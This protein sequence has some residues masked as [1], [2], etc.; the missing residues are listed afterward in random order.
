[1]LV[2]IGQKGITNN[3]YFKE[4]VH[5]IF[6]STF[7]PG[8]HENFLCVFPE[9]AGKKKFC[10]LFYSGMESD[11]QLELINDQMEA[12]TILFWPQFL[13]KM[14]L[15]VVVAT[16]T[17]ILSVFRLLVAVDGDDVCGQLLPD[18]AVLCCPL[19]HHLLLPRRPAA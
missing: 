7:Q 6:D 2:V 16:V 19:L 10:L 15:V 3:L 8:L 18:L 1:M 17:Y 5:Q 13:F 4:A 9:C 14:I 11:D 12:Q